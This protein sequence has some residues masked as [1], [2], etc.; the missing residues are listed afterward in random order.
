VNEQTMKHAQTN[1]RVAEKGRAADGAG[2]RECRHR[3]RPGRAIAQC[4]EDYGID[5]VVIG[6]RPKNALASFVQG[7]TGYKILTSVKRSVFG[8]H[9]PEAVARCLATT[10]AA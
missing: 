6:C 2:G 3:H 1:C 9:A 4:V 7:K 5:L 10:N 8:V